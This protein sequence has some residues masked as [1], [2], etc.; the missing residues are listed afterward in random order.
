MA[1][2]S[3]FQGRNQDFAKGEGLEK[4]KNCDIILMTYFVTQLDN[5]NKMTSCLIFLKFYYIIINLKD[6]ANWQKKNQNYNL[7]KK[8][9]LRE[10]ECDKIRQLEGMIVLQ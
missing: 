7:F 10:L 3:H 5:V 1:M 9:F 6:H 4:W 8:L 2:F